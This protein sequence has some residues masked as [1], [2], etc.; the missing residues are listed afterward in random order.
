MPLTVLIVNRTTFDQGAADLFDEERI[1][2]RL[3]INTF[4]EFIAD[5]LGEDRFEQLAG[6]FLVKAFEL[7]AVSQPLA[8]QVQQ[9]F[10]E[11]PRFFQLHFPVGCHDHHRQVVGAADQVVQHGDRST[12]GPMGIV[13]HQEKRC[14]AAEV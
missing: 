13:N 3:S 10:V 12:V 8:V 7:D 2:V 6:C 9:H 1:A 5:I 14:P 4:Q 11:R